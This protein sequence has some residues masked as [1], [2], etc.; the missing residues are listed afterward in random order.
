MKYI[1]ICLIA[2][3]PTIGFAQIITGTVN[4]VQQKPLSGITV[5]EK[6]TRQATVT[7]DK[8][9]FKIKLTSAQSTLVF[10]AANLETQE[11]RIAGQNVLKIILNPKL[12]TLDEV[13]IIA[14]GTSTQRNSVGSIT[15]VSSAEIQQQPVANP[16]AALEG[17]VAGLSIT[18][19][20]G[21]PGSSFIVQIRGQNTLN[22][23]LLNYSPKDQPLFIIDGVPFSAQNDNI[24][25]FPSAISPGLGSYYGNPYGGVSPFNSI[26][27]ADIE[28][29]EV[30]KDADATAIYG[31]RGGNGVILITTKKG[32]IGKTSL[33]VN[34]D[35]GIS[36]V[37]RTMPMM[38][39]QQY[40]AMRREAFAND[41]L[42]PNNILYDAAYAPDLMVFDQ[43]KYTDWK[44]YFI[45]NTAH[46]FNS[47][48]AVSGGTAN[49]QFRI[50]AGFNRD[51]Y[52]FPGEYGDNRFSFSSNLHHSSNDKKFTLDF[53][54]SY[55]YDK[56]ISSGSQNLLTAFGLEPN[57]PNAVD[58]LGNLLWNYKGVPLDG[59]YATYNPFSALKS[60]YETNSA[61]LNSNL[62]LSYQIFNGLTFRTS[63]GYGT[64]QSN[65]FTSN[66]L[67]SQNPGYN[68]TATA[69]FG[70]LNLNTWIVEPQ[71]EY[72]STFKKA[73]YSILVGSTFQQKSNNSTQVEGS[74]YINDYLIHSISGS[75]TQTA[76][77]ISS[78]YKYSALFARF[79]V[80][81]DGK[82]ILD[83]NGRRDGSSRFGSGKRFG[84]FGSAGA[85]WIFSEES[86]FKDKL[87]LLSYGK[88]RG[89]YGITGSDGVGDYNFISRYAPTVYNY[90]GTLGYLP[91]NLANDQ[92]GW[93]TTKK[94]E[95][96]LELGFLQ[97]RFL[98]TSSW[99][100][101]RSGNQ[102]ISYLLPYQTGF[103]TVVENSS[104][105]VQNTGWEFTLQAKIII[106]QAFSWNA[107]FNASLPKNKLLAFPNLSTSS[108]A[109][110]YIIGRSINEK[111]GFRSAGVNPT[112]GLFQFYDA[113][114]NIISTP[115]S[116]I[117][118]S[119][120][121]YY[122][123]GNLDPKFYGGLSNTFNY[124]NFQLSVFVEFK[125]QNG[126]NYLGQLYATPG[127][128]SNQ[129]EALIAAHWK[130]PGDNAT[131]QKYSSQYGDAAVALSNF[132]QS[133]GIYS[134]ASYLRLK[135]VSLS[136]SVPAQIL[137][138]LSANTLRLYIN[139]QN[140]FTITSYRGSDPETQNF[141]GVPTLRTI[142]G[143][144]QLSF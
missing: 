135:T 78:L 43:S 143:G 41:N 119:L 18:A 45:G 111:I 5:A 47:N 102:L 17:R 22:S 87:T 106:S 38:N 10:T 68:P 37:G 56:N 108:Y 144:L 55:S 60:D 114:G 54:T 96:G 29:I 120:N 66:P 81:W 34:V 40:L 84:N 91:Q 77:D 14:Y 31:S 116:A 23:N 8:G 138:K 141:Y 122:D 79:N 92:F 124:K 95:L 142:T 107:S 125:K 82:Y 115:Q 72:K 104:A 133:D 140:L 59:S 13:H 42:T 21:M 90:N 112:T 63:T 113:N 7:D 117:G 49:T 52:I 134:D 76:S 85:G 99:Y 131:Y 130:G 27:P 33:D 89:S 97:D 101:N 69:N 128:E 103:S 62:L 67:A 118:N 86:F 11:I 121:D 109:T 70:N 1:Y 75:A 53:T 32:K 36:T 98:L 9:E 16:L 80:R 105:L 3:F 127:I 64:F 48:A 19:S 126:I 35:D 132:K 100:R 26:N 20:S 51:T 12:T 129:P 139:A 83:L 57:Y 4:D 137:K 2:L 74:G 44:K 15:K 46:H 30:L 94:L 93:A 88:L 110:T 28:S 65:E 136:Y 24:N 25:Q 61:S 39:T 123:I 73:L 71:V 50:A 58:A 6:G